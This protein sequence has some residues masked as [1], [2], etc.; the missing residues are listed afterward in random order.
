MTEEKEEK[1]IRGVK[2]AKRNDFWDYTIWKW[3][4]AKLNGEGLVL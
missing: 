1:E 2:G 3:L 4:V